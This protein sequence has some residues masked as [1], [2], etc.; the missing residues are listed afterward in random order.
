MKVTT[1]YEGQ[2]R[3][4]SGEGPAQ[5]VM[6]AVPAAGGLGQAPT[7]K[8]MVLQGLAG[9]TGLDVAAILGKKRVRFEGL[10]VD[11]EAEQTTSH[12]KVFKSIKITYRIKADP[13]D[14]QAIERAIELSEKQFCG[15]SAMLRKSAAISWDLVLEPIGG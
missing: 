2:L 14:R 1:S 7:P 15:V 4:S 10:E 5:V 12:P 3:F 11:A 13:A 6:D 9:C 8:E